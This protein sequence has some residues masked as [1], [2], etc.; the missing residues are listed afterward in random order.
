MGPHG[1]RFIDGCHLQAPQ[2]SLVKF[3]GYPIAQLTAPSH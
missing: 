1:E 3:L 2:I